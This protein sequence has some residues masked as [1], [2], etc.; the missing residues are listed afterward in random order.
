[1]TDKVLHS[2]VGLGS[3]TT[4]II[5]IVLGCTFWIILMP[6][7][8]ALAKEGYDKLRGGKFD[9]EEVLATINPFIVVDW[10]FKRQRN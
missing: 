2:A 4:A 6:L 8:L 1:M 10:Y 5:A 3:Y 7:V 9:F